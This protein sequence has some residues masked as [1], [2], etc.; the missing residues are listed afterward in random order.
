MKHSHLRIPAILR[1]VEGQALNLRG[2]SG[3]GR[4]EKRPREQVKT[5]LSNLEPVEGQ[6]LNLRGNRGFGKTRKTAAFKF[7]AC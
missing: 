6:A 2:N 1:P 7:A 3:F 4:N 5:V